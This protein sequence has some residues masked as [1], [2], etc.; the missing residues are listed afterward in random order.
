MKWLYLYFGSAILT[1]V[2]SKTFFAMAVIDENHNHQATQTKSALAGLLQ[3][4]F[5]A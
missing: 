2:V 4:N 3:L 5:D 1:N